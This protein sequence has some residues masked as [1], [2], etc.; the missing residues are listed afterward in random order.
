MS[1]TWRE[2]VR[3]AAIIAFI[4]NCSLYIGRLLMHKQFYE[5]HFSIMVIC[6]EIGF[7][8]S[9]AE[10]ILSPIILRPKWAVAIAA[11]SCIT[12]DLWF[13]DI[14]FWVMVK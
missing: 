4:T 7:V 3:F 5:D 13:S 1:I 14:A 2:R 8:I 9:I 12:A 10:V 11:A 6:A